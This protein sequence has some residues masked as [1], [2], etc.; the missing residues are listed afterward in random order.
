MKRNRLQVVNRKR[1][2]TQK[3][4]FLNLFWLVCNKEKQDMH[5]LNAYDQMKL[6][7]KR[8]S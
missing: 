6:P 8:R 5:N 3:I 4:F 1:D 7:M 2:E